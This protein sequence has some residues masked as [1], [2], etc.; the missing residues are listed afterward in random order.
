MFENC[1]P[2]S[3]DSTI[4]FYYKNTFILDSKINAMSFRD[5]TN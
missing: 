4:N 2:N 5:S 3:L 1:Y